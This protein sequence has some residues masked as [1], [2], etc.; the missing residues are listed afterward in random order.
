LDVQYDDVLK[1]HTY[2]EQRVGIFNDTA[3]NVLLVGEI[4]N[5]P[6]RAV[7]GGMRVYDKEWAG[8]RH[9]ALQVCE[10]AR[11]P[12]TLVVDEELFSWKWVAEHRAIAEL[13][14]DGVEL[15]ILSRVGSEL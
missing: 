2:L 11:R 5:V 3:V 15:G 4:F 12:F 10:G 8:V 6:Y 14:L 7:I 9:F 13:F 1:L